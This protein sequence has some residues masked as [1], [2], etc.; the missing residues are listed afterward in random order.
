MKNHERNPR[1]SPHPILYP[2]PGA[3]ERV[4]EELILQNG[5]AWDGTP[6]D[7]QTDRQTDNPTG[8]DVQL[9]IYLYNVH[10]KPHTSFTSRRSSEYSEAVQY[11]DQR[12]IESS[13]LTAAIVILARWIIWLTVVMVLTTIPYNFQFS[14]HTRTR[15]NFS[16][17]LI[18]IAMYGYTEFLPVYTP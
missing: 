1:P 17:I 2:V 11:T 4:K 15:S 8:C 10:V 14:V 3:Q 7:R 13:N 16:W 12:E 6:V 18:N 5:Q 9:E